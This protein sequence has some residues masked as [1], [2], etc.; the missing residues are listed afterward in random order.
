MSVQII[1]ASSSSIRATLLRNANVPFDVQPARIDEDAIKSAMLAEQARPRDIADAL[2]EQKARRISARNPDALVLGCDQVLEFE[3]ALLSKPA[4]AEEALHRLTD[5]SGKTHHLHSALVLY[6]NAAPVWRHVGHVRLT[7]RD[8][9]ADYLQG[10]IAR[11]WDQVQYSVGA[12]NYEEE[13]VRLFA[14]VD[15]DYFTVLGV[16]L[17]ELLNYLTVRGVLDT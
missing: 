3:G 4:N 6:Q 1:L 11:N 13:G 16:P 7:M 17:L 8:L 10:Y 15:G 9:S 5:M 14:S 12:Y 2:A